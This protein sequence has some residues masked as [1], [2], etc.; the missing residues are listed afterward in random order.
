LR[1]VSADLSGLTESY[2]EPVAV[3]EPAPAP[4][5]EPAP[6]PE[7]EPERPAAP[8]PAPTPS[9]RHIEDLTAGNVTERSAL[10]GYVL[11]LDVLFE[12]NEFDAN[13]LKHF[14]DIVH[15]LA[16]MVARENRVPHWGTV[17]YN[18]G[19][20]LL[21]SKLEGWIKHVNP[22]G[23]I[24]ADGSTPECR[25]CKEVLKRYAKVI[26]QGVR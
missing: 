22:V 1:E 3:P 16:E 20:S 21:A 24:L 26:V 13:G 2:P 5:P 15:P 18:R 25:A 14:S 10:E 23:V 17:E 6:A 4:E 12:K 11:F 8:E 19:G 9:A 7:P